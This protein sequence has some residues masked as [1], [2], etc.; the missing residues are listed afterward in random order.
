MGSRLM[1]PHVLY[2]LPM[3]TLV[4]V[5][6]A[7]GILGPRGTCRLCGAVPGESDLR[8]QKRTRT[9]E[10]PGGVPLPLTSSY[11]S[12]RCRRCETKVP[13]L[14]SSEVMHQGWS[15]QQ[16]M[17]LLCQWCHLQE[18]SSLELAQLGFVDHKAVGER[19]QK[20]LREVVGEEQATAEQ[21]IRLGGVGVDVEVDEV[22]F[23]WRVVT[24][25]DGSKVSEVH[26][27]ICMMERNSRKS[28]LLPLPVRTVAV[29]GRTG[30]ISNEELVAVILPVGRSPTLLPGTVVHTD[31][32]KAYFN[33]GWQGEPSTEQMPEERQ[34][35][36]LAERPCPWRRESE[37][38][39]TERLRAERAAELGTIG[40]RTEVWASRYR[41]LRLVHTAV[42]HNTKPGRKRQFVVMR[43]CHFQPED[44]AVIRARGDD[45]F[46]EGCVSW[47]K[48][49]TQKV[50]GYWRTLRK[51]VAHRGYNT[52]MAEALRTLVLVHQ[53]SH[54]AGP[55]ADLMAHLG[56]T[57][58]QRRERSRVDVEVGQRAWEEVGEEDDVA[59]VPEHV[60]AGAQIWVEQVWRRQA[61]VA[62]GTKRAREARAEE[63]AAKSTRWR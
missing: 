28:L 63:Q 49:G 1:N 21:G 4:K 57:L 16:N 20:P 50:D 45:P 41:H 5:L 29:G 62:R 19:F 22:C 30:P 56:A 47:R 38:E 18:P 6:E 33:L 59:A 53:W 32:A 7:I 36:L 23:R 55:G 10:G 12:W 17:A 46:L 58:K 11:L 35:E 14:R 39:T 9:W 52:S 27:Y 2:Q 34:G 48:G 26:R 13:V 40:G 44:A 61:A 60:H 43:R 31:S 24:K 8:D 15:L 3:L 54:F 51:R 25:E 37:E 42:V